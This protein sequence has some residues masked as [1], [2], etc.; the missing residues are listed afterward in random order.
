MGRI[1]HFLHCG[2]VNP[3]LASLETQSILGMV[4]VGTQGNINN[5]FI[6]VCRNG[7]LLKLC[8]LGLA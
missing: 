4:Y 8:L 6:F 7:Q 1:R 3:R 5:I 2:I